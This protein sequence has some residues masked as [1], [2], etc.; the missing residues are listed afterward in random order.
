MG[1]R[2]SRRRK[3]RPVIWCRSGHVHTL[4]TVIK[5]HGVHCSSSKA[6][7]WGGAS[8][9]HAFRRQKKILPNA[10]LRVTETHRDEL[11]RNVTKQYS[12]R[13]LWV[14]NIRTYSNRSP[15]LYCWVCPFR[16]HA[17]AV[18]QSV[19]SEKLGR[20]VVGSFVCTEVLFLVEFSFTRPGGRVL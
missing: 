3:A 6:D 4:I 13:S 19:D 7:G 8:N 15:P 18:S 12:S 10:V 2:S 5:F 16:A 1:S 11:A 9:L 20:S 14:L 17:R